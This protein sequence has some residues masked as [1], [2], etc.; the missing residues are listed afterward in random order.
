[1]YL[2]EFE[3]LSVNELLVI[4][5]AKTKLPEIQLPEIHHVCPVGFVSIHF[6]CYIY[7]TSVKFYIV[8]K[9]KYGFIF[10]ISQ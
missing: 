10:S 5:N 3:R 2:E 7:Y 1:M 6:Q 9:Y 4:D 8:T